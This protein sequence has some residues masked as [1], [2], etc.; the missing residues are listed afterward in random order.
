MDRIKL[1]ICAIIVTFN[2]KDLLCKSIEAII[3]QTI[4]PE[5]I[6]I[7]DNASTD[8]TQSELQQRYGGNEKIE[9][10]KLTYL[11]NYNGII[12]NYF[13]CSTNEGGAG[14]FYTGLKLAHEQN[15][16]DFFWLMDD[17]GYPSETCLEEQM[18]YTQDSDYVMPLSVDINNHLQLSWATRKKNGEKTIIVKELQEEWGKTMPFIFPFNGSL[19]SKKI[20]DEVGYINPKLFIWGDDY[21]HYYRCLKKGF[22][23]ITV[24]D[25]IFYHPVNK[26]PT[27]PVMFGKFQVPYVESELRFV[28]LI[29][30]WAYI[31]KTNHRYVA[32]AKTLAAYSWLFLIT[33]KLN[34]KKFILFIAS[35]A[36]GLRNNFERHKKYLPKQ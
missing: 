15:L 20:V 30:N 31:N 4:I 16:F 34:V 19:L 9:N 17:D 11:S 22:T 28:C 12:I 18:K 2:R 5:A 3:N 21:E 29:R 7:I 26:A 36:D 10:N 1:K 6:L 35:F 25:A 13:R 14:G 33:Q 23:P 32:M 27:V 24:L 8:G